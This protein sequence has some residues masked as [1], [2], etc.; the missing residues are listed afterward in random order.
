M[1][2]RVV[3]VG[4]SCAGLMAAEG[5]R[6][7][8]WHDEIVL[9]GEE[10]G[11]PYD[12]PPLSKSFLANS[13]DTEILLRQPEAFDSLNLRHLPGVSADGVE[14]ATRTVSTDAGTFEADGVIL[15][16]GV[17]ARRLEWLEHDARVR[18]VRT[19]EDGIALSRDL[20]GPR[21]TL[22][23]LGGG[24]LGL[25]TAATA[26]ALGWKVHLLEAGPQIMPTML[27]PG[28]AERVADHHR[29]N[30][31]TVS[32]S[33]TVTGIDSTGLELASGEHVDMNLCVVAVGSIP[34]TEW[35]V[36]SEG[37]VIDNGVV[38]D[39]YG[40]AAPNIYAAGDVARWTHSGFGRSIRLESRTNAVR[41]A[42]AV[43]KNLY[44]SLSG[45]SESCSEY[46]PEP[47]FWSDQG[48]L[49]LKAFGDLGGSVR[50]D[51][52]GDGSTGLTLF[53]D[54]SGVLVGF[55]ALG[56]PIGVVNMLRDSMTQRRSVT[57][58]FTELTSSH[59]GLAQL[60]PA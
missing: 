12:R 17:R 22:A 14:V 27:G 34:N 1:A 48:A 50:L 10:L 41:Q 58:N 36:G 25:E 18:Y 32:T 49:R 28:L 57:E 11:L 5:L 15:T 7:A 45:L 9:L 13:E 29:R 46:S 43:A 55:S 3:V 38:C 35:L 24:P 19:A 37:L 51:L 16:T 53:G 31:I 26:A 33:T 8:G 2:G 39:S 44:C 23:V 59:S 20:H 4:A 30:G 40:A 6:R 47:F 52:A 42:M 56:L 60:T 21:G 54:E